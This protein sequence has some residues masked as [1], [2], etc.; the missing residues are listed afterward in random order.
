M[1]PFIVVLISIMSVSIQ[2]QAPEIKWQ[3]CFGTN[4]YNPS[5]GIITTDD[6]Y[7]LATGTSNG[8]GL[9]NYH[10]GGDIWLVE[11][12]TMGNKLWEKCYGGSGG[13]GP[14][15][16]IR[17]N[18]NYFVL[19][20]TT[21][22]DGDV[23]SINNGSGDY[24]VIKLD[25][26]KE[27]IWEKCYGSPGNEA[28]RDMIATPD[29][30]VV[31]MGRIINSGGDVSVYYG[32]NDVWMFKTDS[33]GNIEWEKTLG[34][35]WND[36]GI[37][38]ILNSEGN[39]MLIGA[40]SYYGGLVECDVDD[41]YGDVWLV[42]LDLQGN[43][44]SQYCY[45][46]SSYDVGVEI[47]ENENGYIFIA[48]SFS[49]DGDVSGHHGPA[50]VPPIGW[51][52]FWIVKINDEGEILWQNSFGGYDSENAEFITLTSDG[53][54][55]AIGTTFSNDGDVSGNHSAPEGYDT[56]IW[57]VKLT[58]AGEIEWQRCYGGWGDERLENPHTILKKSDYNYVIASSTD[59]VSG[60]DDIECGIHANYDRDA[61][62]F[63]IDIDDTTGIFD[64]PARQD[65]IKVYPNP[66][67]DY[68][69][70]KFEVQGS[71]FE[72]GGKYAKI[73]I[74]NVFGQQVATLLLTQQKTVWDT[75]AVQNG[76]Y[77]Y[78]L[79]IEGKLYDGKVVLHK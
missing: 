77:F 79:E 28:P 51:A 6:G 44:I 46:G 67:K 40:A 41:Y 61:W 66:A 9:P 24:W 43:I 76:I 18:D 36:N 26:E 74:I 4:G 17:K 47:E 29:G 38:I 48:G 21:S 63:E 78:S 75:R 42:E 30:G 70:F 60:W 71:K 3:T 35:Q 56:D 12:D 54:I 68:V 50:G 65:I 72:V 53:G 33:V 22:T 27:I 55:L 31:V 13:D 49:N 69:I 73:Q 32:S 1:R 52:D 14:F 20:G 2:G 37:S 58:Y 45:G 39:I 23:Q 11:I 7:L 64:T 59:F 34:N 57:A 10:G 8:E 62:I 25:F 16:L 15:K 19:A 5:Y